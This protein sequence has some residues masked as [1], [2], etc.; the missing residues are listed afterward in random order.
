VKN[1]IR[2]TI[3]GCVSRKPFTLIE[4]LVIIAIIAILAAVL[5]PALAS[6]KER[7]ERAS[8]KNS[9][10]LLGLTLIKYGGNNQDRFPTCVR[11]DRLK[12]SIWIGTPNYSRKLNATTGTTG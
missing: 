5:L 8:C 12:H 4:L 10:R 11:D 9:L 2:S 6:A 7:A 1:S 3:S